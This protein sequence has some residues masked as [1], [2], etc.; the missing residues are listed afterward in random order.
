MN[1]PNH[2]NPGRYGGPP[3]GRYGPA[4][5]PGPYGPPPGQRPPGPPGRPYGP[6]PGHP[7]DQPTRPTGRP[8]GYGPGPGQ[9]PGQQGYDPDT[10]PTDQIYGGPA[11]EY[12]G[13]PPPPPARSLPDLD[14]DTPVRNTPRPPASKTGGGKLAKVIGLVVLLAVVAG[15]ALWL[16]SG[17]PSSAEV[18]DCIKINNIAEAD[19]D[20]VDCASE[21]ALYKVAVTS[22]DTDARCPSPAYL[23][24]SET[25]R[26]ELL[27]CLALNAEAGECYLTTEQTHKKV[28]C[29][30]PDAMFQVSDVFAG[31]DDPAQCGEAAEQALVYP[32]P[33]L[34][35][36]RVAPD[37]SAT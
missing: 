6:P 27:L 36:C 19:I 4:G 20:K 5:Q 8:P 22:S 30:A 12:A 7:G 23:A 21:E 9:G 25:G 17:S 3:P 33:P 26:N 37:T 1:T 14:D 11:R 24:Y 16:Q 31:K 29:A 32:E 18:G 28:D 15:V 10:P 13:P 2:P 35:I 34:T